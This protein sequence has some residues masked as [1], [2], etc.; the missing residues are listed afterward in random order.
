MVDFDNLNDKRL[1]NKILSNPDFY[2]MRRNE[3]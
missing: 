3:I 1:Q 2:K